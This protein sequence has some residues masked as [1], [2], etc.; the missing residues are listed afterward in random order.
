MFEVVGSAGPWQVSLALQWVRALAS[1]SQPFPGAVSQSAKP[2]SQVKITQTPAAQPIVSTLER[3]VQGWLQAAQWEASVFKLASQPSVGSALQSAKPS[4]Q[5]SAAHC[6]FWHVAWVVFGR[7][8]Q[9]GVQGVGVSVGSTTMSGGEKVSVGFVSGTGTK[10]SGGSVNDVSGGTTNVSGSACV[11]AAV[12]KC[13]EGSS[14]QAQ[15]GL[16]TKHAQ[17]IQ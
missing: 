16:A 11:S 6:P 2:S 9:A 1:V 12:D 17:K 14:S 15:R 3:G 4:A 5:M 7:V 10:V 8:S 13:V